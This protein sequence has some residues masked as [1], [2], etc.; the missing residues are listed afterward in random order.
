M[1]KRRP[2]PESVDV[3]ATAGAREAPFPGFVPLCHPTLRSKLPEGGD[4]LY[5]AKLDGYSA[6]LHRHD[7][8]AIAYTR[9]GLDW[10]AEFA[11]ICLREIM[12]E[13]T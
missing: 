8:A 7:G 10:S 1:A 9:N 12:V 13:M 5:E 4:W 3:H 11:P 2:S 6:Q